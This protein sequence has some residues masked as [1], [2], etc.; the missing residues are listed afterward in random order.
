M[1]L[2]AF[3]YTD[4]YTQMIF[5][6]STPFSSSAKCQHL[7]MRE[8]DHIILITVFSHSSL[9]VTR[10]VGAFNNEMNK[11][12][13]S[14]RHENIYANLPTHFVEMSSQ[15]TI[16]YAFANNNVKTNWKA[17][18]NQK[19]RTTTAFSTDDLKIITVVTRSRVFT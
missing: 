12:K 9:V 18:W 15:C 13:N 5:Y 1:P 19:K 11:W 3:P 8:N 14:L 10:L 6:L 7:I 4:L 2:V 16:L 17:R